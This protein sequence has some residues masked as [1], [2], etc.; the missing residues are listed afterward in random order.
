[1]DSC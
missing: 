1:L